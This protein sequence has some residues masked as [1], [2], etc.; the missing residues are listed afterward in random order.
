MASVFLPVGFLE[1]STGVFYRQFAF[2]LAIAVLIS[3]VN[4]LTLSPALCALFLGDLHQDETKSGAHRFTGFQHRFFT[5]FNTGF[6]VL[7]RRYLDVLVLL[8]RKRNLS[9]I[10]LALITAVAFWMFKST[11]TGFIPDEDNGFVIV[12][13]SMPPGASLERTQ[14]TMDRAAGSLRQMEAVN[15]VISVA[16]IN[17]LSRSSS[18]SSG[19]IFMQLKDLHERGSGGDIKNVLGSINGRLSAIKEGSF[20]ALSMPTVPGFST[21][22]GLEFVLQDR[23]GGSLEAFNGVS[24]QF[25]GQLMQRPEIAFAFTTFNATYPQFSLEVDAA[26][27][28][29][30]GG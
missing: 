25:I 28:K 15:R 14:V 3:A 19:L 27:A 13:V 24:Q 18:P 21:V 23:S 16:G 6:N 20:F 9:L 29:R 22:G 17:I 12:S 30:M 1:G 11:P 7:K 4:A 8:L 2:T 5:G 10:G 26:R